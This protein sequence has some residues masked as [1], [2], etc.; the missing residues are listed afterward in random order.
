MDPEILAMIALYDLKYEYCSFD[1][2]SWQAM[3]V[4]A[5]ATEI[6]FQATEIKPTVWPYEI[7]RHR[8]ES[9]IAPGPAML[10][11]PSCEGCDGERMHPFEYYKLKHLVDLANDG[12]KLPRLRTVLPPK[13]HRY[14]V[15]LRESGYKTW[16]N[17][18]Y[19][20]REFAKEIGAY[21]IDDYE[22]T[23]IHLHERMAIYAGA[24][25]NFGISGGPM[26][27]LSLSEYPCM[28]FSI[29]GGMGD[30][31]GRMERQLARWGIVK[32]SQ[33][34]WARTDQIAVW[35]WDTRHVL[36]QWFERWQSIRKM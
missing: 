11:L 12:T 29:G 36:G 24:E 5:G 35:E 20:W 7:C 10:E 2:Y 21:V 28:I 9:I 32:G 3:A 22:K 25:M 31:D 27:M 6:R 4:A 34:P 18:N 1:F 23:P 8:F 14:T 13:S 17:S 26:W 16:R 33:L 15:T 19:A 30:G